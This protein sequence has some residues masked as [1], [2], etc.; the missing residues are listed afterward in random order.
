MGIILELR[1]EEDEAFRWLRQGAEGGDTHAAAHL[2]KL[3]RRRGETAEAERWL[4]RATE[5]GER[6]GMFELALL[7]EHSERYAEARTWYERTADEG[8][9]HAARNLGW[10][11]SDQ[12]EAAEGAER[13]FGRA[14]E[15]GDALGRDRARHHPGQP[16]RR[17]RRRTVM[18]RRGRA[19][20]RAR[21][22]PAG[23]PRLQ[24]RRARRGP[25]LVA[26][27]RRRRQSTTPATGSR[28]TTDLGRSRRLDRLS[29]EVLG[30]AGRVSSGVAGAS[31]QRRPRAGAPSTTVGLSAP[32]PSA[33]LRRT[34]ELIKGAA[35][36]RVPPARQAGARWG[37][38]SRRPSSRCR[39][40]SASTVG[41]WMCLTMRGTWRQREAPLRQR[42]LR[43]VS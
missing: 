9:A 15:G 20:Q 14:P 4:R 33:E 43:V 32:G 8:L 31:W 26:A 5:A 38:V 35:H 36:Q 27:G 28:R 34:R 7:L 13:W 1:G 3:L 12:L 29:L 40:S 23:A 2:G 25:H 42:R 18:A 30:R 22:V 24:P 39:W 41:S 6:E 11:L 37:P 10:L 16:R 19:G 17:G 21:H